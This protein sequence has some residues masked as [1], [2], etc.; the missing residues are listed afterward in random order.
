MKPLRPRIAHHATR[1]IEKE[2]T[3]NQRQLAEAGVDP[4][5]PPK[6]EAFKKMVDFVNGLA[7][8]PHAS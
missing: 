1:Q 2:F 4:V 5:A 3:E 8:H 7:G 6:G